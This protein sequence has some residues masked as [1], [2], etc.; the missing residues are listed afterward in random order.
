MR[1][2]SR[3]Q[4]FHFINHKHVIAA[5]DVKYENFEII[6]LYNASPWTMGE[7]LQFDRGEGKISG[8]TLCEMMKWILRLVDFRADSKK[9]MGET[10]HR[11]SLDME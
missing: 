2:G 8:H 1:S 3:H 4:V 11:R 6:T 9:R 7:E 10:Y 5:F